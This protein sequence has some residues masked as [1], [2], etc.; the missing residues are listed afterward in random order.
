MHNAAFYGHKECLEILLAHDAVVNTEEGST[1]ALH[2]AAF[3]GHLQCLVLLLNKKVYS[4]C[5]CPLPTSP[6][7]SFDL[8]LTGWVCVHVGTQASV[9]ARDAEG[10][11]PLHKAAY[12]GQLTCLELLLERGADLSIQDKEGS[13]PAHKAAYSN[14]TECLTALLKRGAEVDNRDYDSGTPLHNAAFGGHMES[15]EVRT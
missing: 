7:L 3:N 2:H 10:A 11:T 5:L 9:N 8:V 6:L 14:R 4:P 13:S 12:T 1:S 15:L